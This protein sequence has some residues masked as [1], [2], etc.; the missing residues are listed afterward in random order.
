MTT[1]V[2]MMVAEEWELPLEKVRVSLADARP[3]LL[4][5]QLTGGSHSMRSV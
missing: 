4:M 3:E 2:A 5:N 1:A